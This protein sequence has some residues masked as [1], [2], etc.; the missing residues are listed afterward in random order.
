[1]VSSRVCKDGMC[2]YNTVRGRSLGCEGVFFSVV[3]SLK[4]QCR[5]NLDCVLIHSYGTFGVSYCIV[6]HCVVLYYFVLA[7]TICMLSSLRH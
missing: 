6:R 3:L 4:M 2:V 5:K 7:Y 1:M